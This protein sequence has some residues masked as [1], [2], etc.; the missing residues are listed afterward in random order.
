MKRA[1]MLLFALVLLVPVQS[2]ATSSPPPPVIQISVFN[3]S[4]SGGRVVRVFREQTA[5]FAASVELPGG[6]L[7]RVDLYFGF[8]EPG[9]TKPH[10]WTRDGGAVLL[11]P[12]MQ[13]LLEDVDISLPPAM[14]NT[15]VIEGKDLEY[16]FAGDAPTG[17]YMVF[18]LVVI[19]NTDPA[20]H[21]N[22]YGVGAVPLFVE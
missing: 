9:N 19:A 7:P 3:N 13:P 15:G 11:Q 22:W 6:F 14:L 10:T 17:M 2:E 5:A 4:L 18:A 8:L 20:D 1:V 21:A 16:R 12:G